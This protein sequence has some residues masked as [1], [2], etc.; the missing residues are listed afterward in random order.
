[1]FT[2]LAT[3]WFSYLFFQS[4]IMLSR[5]WGYWHHMPLQYTIL[6]GLRLSMCIFMITFGVATLNGF[7]LL[8]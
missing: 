6:L 3:I 2:F 8:P 5:N 1:M 4:I 7:R